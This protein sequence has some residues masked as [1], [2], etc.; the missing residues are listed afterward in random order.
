M[1]TKGIYTAVSGALAQSQRLDQIA[2]NLANVNTPAFKRDEAVFREYLSAYEKPPD[3]NS[4]PRV[5]ASIESFYDLQGGDKAYADAIGTYTDHSQGALKSTGNPLDLA[6]E[7]R[8]FLEVL[9]ADGP[10]LTRNGSLKVDSEGRVVTRDGLPL[11]L[12]GESGG[13]PSERV[14]RVR[15]ANF[16]VSPTGE[17]YEDN[18]P[19][20]KL[21]LL[22]AENKDSIRKQGASLYS[23]GENAVLS[24]ASPQ[25]HQG[26]LE[27]SNVNLIREMTDM[28]AATRLFESSQKAIQAYDQ[29][30]DKLVN[31]VPKT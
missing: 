13:D 25:I 22:D 16:V 20:G 9:T 3:L 5:T 8:G 6:L 29:M 11:L 12:E 4:V 10:R 24:V 31:N 28:I 14:L 19:V 15:S 21:S 18:V 26:F 7:G 17:V 23:V 27:S 30:E 2:N 1:S